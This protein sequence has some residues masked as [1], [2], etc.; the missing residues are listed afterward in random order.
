MNKICVELNKN[1]YEIVVGTSLDAPFSCLKTTLREY[2][3]GRT[4]FVISDE[5]VS[6]LYSNRL[7]QV[8]LELGSGEVYISIFPAGEES[9][10]LST[11][12]N[13]FKQAISK[14]IDR[15]SVVVVLGGGV[16]GD[17]GGFMAA[18]YMRGIDLVQ[19]PTS[20]VAAVDSSI[21]GKTGIDLDE[22]KNLI[23]AFYQPKTVQIDVKLLSTLPI[24]ELRC[25]LAEIIKY[26]VILDPGLFSFLEENIDGLL[27]FDIEIYERLISQCCKLKADIV[28]VDEFDKGARAILNYGHTFGHALEKLGK[29][30]G[31]NHGEAISIGMGM[32]CDLA[33]ALYKDPALVELSSRQEKLFVSLGLPIQVNGFSANEVLNAM[34]TDKKFE[35]GKTKLILPEKFGSVKVV[36]DID[37][38]L[39]LQTINGRCDK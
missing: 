11:V 25:G 21:G 13:L 22:G 4:C 15:S 9:K 39:I 38:E 23:G 20:L 1:S 29:Y 10:C 18:T 6:N 8:L 37:D 14:G 28:S 27:N 33:S 30:S 34:R 19:L 2:I 3:M 5:I 7:E 35:K 16:V 24:R 32:A 17:T 26:G 12:E 31:L 36:S